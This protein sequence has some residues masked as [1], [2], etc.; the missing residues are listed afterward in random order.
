MLHLPPS[1]GLFPRSFV[2]RSRETAT[3]LPA[4]L[5]RANMPSFDVIWNR[6]NTEEIRR[7]SD[8]WALEEVRFAVC[9]YACVDLYLYLHLSLS[10]YNYVCTYVCI[11][12]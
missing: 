2:W 12:R 5:D 10:I 7:R 3:S 11:Y 9:V 8:R 1:E 6:V 4:Y